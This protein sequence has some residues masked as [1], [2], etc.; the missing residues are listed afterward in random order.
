MSRELHNIVDMLEK[1][2]PSTFNNSELPDN[3]QE[4]IANIGN[5]DNLHLLIDPLRTIAREKKLKIRL[6]ERIHTI[7]RYSWLLTEKE[8]KVFDLCMLRKFKPIDFAKMIV[9]YDLTDRDN[10]LLFDSYTKSVKTCLPAVF[11]NFDV[12]KVAHDAWTAVHN[13]EEAFPGYYVVSYRIFHMGRILTAA[14]KR[15]SLAQVESNSMYADS[16]APNFIKSG[17]TYNFTEQSAASINE[18]FWNN[19]DDLPAANKIS[20]TSGI[21]F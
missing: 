10:V 4:Y 3:I 8:R 12:D 21:T 2:S 20:V 5:L 13:K 14:V 17:D 16:N 7:L 15:L 18:F 19:L 9:K 11:L 1:F 6:S